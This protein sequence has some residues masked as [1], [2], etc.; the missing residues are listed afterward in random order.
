MTSIPIISII[1]PTFNHAEYL[2]EALQSICAQTFCDWE[3]IV[4]N[5]FSEDDTIEVVASFDDSRIHLE[6]F[7]NS[8]VIAASRNRGIELARGRY[9]AFL[10]SDDKW[11][12]EKLARCIPFFSAGAE[13][14]GHGLQWIGDQKRVVFCG[15]ENMA[16]F[17]ALL[18][19][20]CCLTTSSTIVEKHLVLAAGGF[21]EDPAIVT[22]EDYHFWMKLA[23]RGIKVHFIREV[24]GEYR[25]HSANQSGAVLRHLNAVLCVINEFFPKEDLR[26][27]KL[28]MRIRRRYALAFYGAGRA[29]QRNGQFDQWW[30]LLVC[31]VN[32]WPFFLKSYIAIVLGLVGVA[33]KKRTL[34]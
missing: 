31:S 16:S 21:S 3:A 20:G 32:Y 18:Y 13:L 34:L 24:L 25:V 30:R 27:F 11:Y 28:R 4:I 10:D 7:R 19:E 6:N 15:P 2:R 8:G 12:P 1:I 33:R 26:D 23:Q 22:A 14:V 9:L 5:N 17:S 29:M